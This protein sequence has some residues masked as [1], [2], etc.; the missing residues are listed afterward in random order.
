M[1]IEDRKTKT[2]FKSYLN[3]NKIQSDLD[4]VLKLYYF[5]IK[6][7][8]LINK[9]IKFEIYLNYFCIF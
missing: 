7:T 6:L 9:Y 4:I 1:I 3:F 5:T 2:N 8:L